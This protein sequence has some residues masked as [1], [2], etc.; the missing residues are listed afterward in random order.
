MATTRVKASNH[1]QVYHRFAS[2]N[3]AP[4]SDVSTNA[5]GSTGLGSSADFQI[6]ADD[7][8]TWTDESSVAA[9]SGETA[10]ESLGSPIMVWIKHSGYQDA[11][12]ATASTATTKVM[13][14]VGGAAANG[15]ISL[16]PDQS[17]L[18]TFP[19]GS[20]VDNLDDFDMITSASE[21]V[22]VEVKAAI[23]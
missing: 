14:G 3:D 1:T 19:F 22:Y 17:I 21:A 13:I 7:N 15:F 10:M 11:A 6:D 4:E 9:A 12:K 8:Q 20:N 23:D 16:Y 5:A 18:L 2:S